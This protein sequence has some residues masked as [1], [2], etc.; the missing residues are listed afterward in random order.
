MLGQDDYKFPFQ[1][2]GHNTTHELWASRAVYLVL[3]VAALVLY[4]AYSANFISSLAVH[5]R[6]FSLKTF[7]DLLNDGTFKMGVRA[8]STHEDYFKVCIGLIKRTCQ[9]IL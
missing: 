7:Q 5:K 1:C 2:T 4:T 6:D 9:C 8:K 3:H